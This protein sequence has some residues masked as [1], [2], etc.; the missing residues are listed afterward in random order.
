MDQPIN[1]KRK[2]SERISLVLISAAAV[3]ALSGC[4]SSDVRRDVYA[5]KEDCLAD[6][7]NDPKDCEPAYDH[8]GSRGASTYYYGRPYTF[9]GGTASP[10][11]TGKTVGSMT[12]TTSRGGF[13]TSAR[14][15]GS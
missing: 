7:G 1:R 5:N 11:R 15:S 9:R 13:G 14:S 4:E 6:W 10:S 3:A 12:S 8:P 2:S